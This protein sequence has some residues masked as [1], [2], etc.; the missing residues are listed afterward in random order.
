MKLNKSTIS[1]AVIIISIFLPAFVF[2]DA[3]GAMVIGMIIFYGGILLGIFFLTLIVLFLVYKHKK[4]N[5]KNTILN[6]GTIFTFSFIVMVAFAFL[7]YGY[8]SAVDSGY[9]SYLRCQVN[10]S[11]ACAYN[12]ARIGGN[13]EFCLYIDEK[14][15][16]YGTLATTFNRADCYFAVARKKGDIALCEFVGES[17]VTIEPKKDYCIELVATDKKDGALCSNINDLSMRNNCY[18]EIGWRTRNTSLCDRIIEDKNR[19]D[20]C[21]GEIASMENNSSLCEKIE[22]LSYRDACFKSVAVHTGNNSLCDKI[23][24]DKKEACLTE[25]ESFGRRYR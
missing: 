1:F 21:Y 11:S 25:V 2:A 4:R 18:N 6:L 8:F 17:R 20:S 5:N 3:M 10:P 13:E 16:G 19:K 22:Q 14:V 24:E 7:G 9:L 15:K 23:S 12:A